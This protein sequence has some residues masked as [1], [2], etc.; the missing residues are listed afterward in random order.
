M[1][2]LNKIK[3]NKEGSNRQRKEMLT[4]TSLNMNG[5]K[6]QIHNTKYGKWNMG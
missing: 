1:L 3:E 2:I 5:G 4:F 6:I